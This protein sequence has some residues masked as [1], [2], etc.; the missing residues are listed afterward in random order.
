VG[1][2]FLP[3]L[4][5]KGS[6][7]ADWFNAIIHS[8][9][10]HQIFGL[11]T[12][13]DMTRAV[14]GLIVWPLDFSEVVL[15][16]G[17]RSLGIPP[18]PWVISTGLAAV[19]GWYLKGWRLALLSGTCIAYFAIFGKW[20]LAMTTLSLVLVTAPIAAAI[21]LVLGILVADRRSVEKLLWPLLNLMQSLPHFGY[22]IPIVVFVGLGHKAGAIAT[23]VFAMPPMAKLTVI[24]LRGVS[25]EVLEAGVMAGCTPRQMLWR[26]R[27][28]AARRTLMVG[29]NQVIMQCLAMVVIA[30]FIGARGLGIDLLFRLQT[31]QLGR[32]L[33]SGIA[34]VLMAVTLD[35]LSQALS[36]KEP[37][38][39]RE[40]SF[41]VVRVYLT[42]AL[43][44]VV[45]GTILAYFVP[46]AAIWPR[47]MAI[48]LAP[49]WDAVI[50]QTVIVLYEPLNFIR[51]TLP[52]YVLMPIR[53]FFQ[54]LPWT[55]F[56]GV[57][58]FM[59][60]CLGGRRMATIIG[61]YI[62]FIAVSG[63]WTETMVTMYLVFV[64]VV[65]CVVIGFPLGVW[66]SR[67]D[68][69]TRAVAFLCDTFQT[70]P[71][72]IYLIPVIML[73]Q[74]GTISQIMAIVIYSSIP[75]VRYTIFGLR[76]VPHEIIE[77]A[78][79][80]GST[81]RQILWKVR[82]PMAFPE[83]MLGLNQ[84]IMF[85]LFMVMIAGFIGGN[86]D[87]A[88]EIFKAK[89]NN[90]AGL[91]LLLA[92]CVACLGLATDRLI[93]AWANQRKAQLGIGWEKL[94]TRL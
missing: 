14:T 81:P 13:R 25:E 35:R 63:W 10:T 94:D 76:G 11:F 28:P 40:G 36:E 50:L 59:G 37:E 87:L 93:L 68:S 41:W 91:G 64:A 49:Q 43:I 24:G 51:D 90:D 30:A 55:V 20:K 80:S 89:A 1:E 85:G 12:F 15:I 74:V 26:V 42:A 84:T 5:W 9:R 54:G 16:S 18:I 2:E 22:L 56:L 86:H 7:V 4:R 83:I 62:A 88:R 70:F 73:F 32:A 23:I 33:E 72:F 82:M 6:N 77:A 46:Q 67:R 61:L 31:L 52:P 78:I 27:V 8:L 53:D 47:D 71:S 34:I 29:V 79:M 45:I 66:A 65:I 69:T 48:T 57:S 3:V 75:V 19:L 44:V 17:S 21:G 38:H 58:T 39:Q 60:W 92:L